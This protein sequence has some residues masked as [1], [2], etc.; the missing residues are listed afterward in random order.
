M[1]SRQSPS[2][3]AAAGNDVRTDGRFDVL[4]AQV[5]GIEITHPTSRNPFIRGDS[6]GDVKGDLSDAIQILQY[7]F[8]GTSTPACVAAAKPNGER[9]VDLTDHIGLLGFL[10]LG[11]AAP[12]APYPACGRGTLPNGCQ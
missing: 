10:F 6:N 2:F 11:G 3:S 9:K 1:A 4:L 5:C 8:L 7:L 12:V